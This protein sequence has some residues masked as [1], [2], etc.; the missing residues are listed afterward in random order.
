[1]ECDKRGVNAHP[2]WCDAAKVPGV[3][4]WV[5]NGHQYSGVQNLKDLAK[6][7]SYKGD[8]NFKYVYMPIFFSQRTLYFYPT[9]HT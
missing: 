6:A 8:K 7:S 3:P 9:L 1:M 2:D 4:T 5:I